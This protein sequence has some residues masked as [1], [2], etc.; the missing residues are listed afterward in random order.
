[1]VEST[2]EPDHSRLD[3][4]H[5]VFSYEVKIENNSDLRVQLLSR[6]WYINDLLVGK[7]IVEGEG[8]VGEQPIFEIGESYTYSSWCPLQSSM[9]YMKGFFTFVDLL[10]NE[11]FKVK[12]PQFNFQPG[13][14]KN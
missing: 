6:E 13:F 7:H 3:E 4:Q 2:Y 10:T 5:F 1:M 12:V 11:R 9:G 14:Q 8:V